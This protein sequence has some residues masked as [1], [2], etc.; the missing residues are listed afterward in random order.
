MFYYN[1][2]L[3]NRMAISIHTLQQIPRVPVPIGSCKYDLQ[4]LLGFLEADPNFDCN[5]YLPG[6]GCN[7]PL[8][9]G[10]YG[11]P[12]GSEGIVIEL[13]ADF[14]I[15]SIIKP[16]LSGTIKVELNMKDSGN[17]DMVC[18]KLEIDVEF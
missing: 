5:E 17:N 14:A 15:P 16:V 4:Q 7:L 1:R 9:P 10:H 2:T 12:E 13:P 6:N 18:A 8:L 11:G 3:L